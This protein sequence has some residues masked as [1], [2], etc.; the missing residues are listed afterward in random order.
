[1]KQVFLFRFGYST[2]K[3]FINNEKY[4]WED[5]DSEAVYI[6]AENAEQ[7]LQCGYDIADAFLRMLFAD[8]SVSWRAMQF[9]GVVTEA[10][11]SSD[12]LPIVEMGQ[13]PDFNRMI[14]KKYGDA[15]NV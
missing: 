12:D 5:E 6:L 9:A 14:A 1:M 2:P 8:P 13:H 15:G 10:Q 4:G 11:H 7:A 3:Q